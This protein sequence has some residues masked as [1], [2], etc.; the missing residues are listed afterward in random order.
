MKLNFSLHSYVTVLE[1]SMFVPFVYKYVNV[2]HTFQGDR[3]VLE[4]DLFGRSF[5]IGHVCST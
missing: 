3:V 5:V 1:E 4:L 2:Q